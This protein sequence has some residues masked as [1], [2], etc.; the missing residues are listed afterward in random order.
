[1]NVCLWVVNKI[2]PFEPSYVISLIFSKNQQLVSRDIK[3]CMLRDT[4]KLLLAWKRE[5]L[6][7]HCSALVF[8]VVWKEKNERISSDKVDNVLKYNWPVLL[9]FWCKQHCYENC[10]E[11]EAMFRFILFITRLV[12]HVL[13]WML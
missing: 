11:L 13:F 6:L 12:V 10:I 2:I 3:W 7:N 5:P 4:L 1:M 8:R 9:S